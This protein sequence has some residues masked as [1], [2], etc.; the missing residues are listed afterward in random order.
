MV[1]PLTP[2]ARADPVQA[3]TG[4]VSALRRRPLTWSQTVSEQWKLIKDPY[5]PACLPFEVRSRLDAHHY[6]TAFRIKS[7]GIDF[8]VDRCTQMYACAYTSFAVSIKPL[9]YRVNVLL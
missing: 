9:G 8:R 4:H 5:N 2:S 6:T 1:I 3:I 7:R